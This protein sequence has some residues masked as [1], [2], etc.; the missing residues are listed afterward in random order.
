MKQ[1]IVLILAVL[2]GLLAFWLTHRYLRGE[3]DKI[4][5]GAEKIQILAA[6]RDIPA[7]TVLEAGDLGSKSVYKSAVGENIFRPEDLKMVLGKK[8]RYSLKRKEPL[9]WSY[10]EGAGADSG[11]LAPMIR[12]G[13][14][15]I[16][17]AVGGEAAVSGLV[18]PN[19]RVDI[20]G[21]FIFPSRNH[22]GEMETVTLTLLQDVSILATGQQLGKEDY[23]GRSRYAGRS[24]GYSMVTLEVTP[25]EAEVLV[26]AQQVKGRLT[27]SLRNPEDVSFE[28]Q[29]PEIDF[30]HIEHNLPDLNAYRQQ[31]IRHKSGRANTRGNTP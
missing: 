17:I 4:Y 5:K 25:R 12:P 2:A 29:L 7:G 23:L 9:W 26:F 30:S 1:K 27:L 15:A 31:T 13:L 20:L 18:Q 6:A 8:I 22:P 3:V 24:G 28:E 10:V 19:D 21:T 14:R 16:S 11:G